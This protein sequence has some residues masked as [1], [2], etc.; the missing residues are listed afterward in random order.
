MWSI[1]IMT[2]Y[3]L[4]GDPP[5]NAESDQELFDTIVKYPVSY[6]EQ[7]WQNVSKDCID[8]VQELLIKDPSQRMTAQQAL[9]H[10]FLK[11]KLSKMSES[12]TM[13]SN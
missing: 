9:E 6:L 2:Y 4:V 8:F 11:P 12:E 7:D 13:S 3:M 5:F 1:G 10:P